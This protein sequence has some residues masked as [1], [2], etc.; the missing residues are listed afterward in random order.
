M[1]LSMNGVVP[2]TAEGGTSSAVPG[3]VELKAARTEGDGAMNHEPVVGRVVVMGPHTLSVRPFRKEKDTCARVEASD[4]NPGGESSGV[5]LLSVREWLLPVS[6]ERSAKS[7][8]R[9][10]E[11][12][13]E[14]EGERRADV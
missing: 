1:L 8:V 7:S 6:S 3:A 5:K 13:I 12:A 4:T 2:V 11:E 10:V 9:P 14:R